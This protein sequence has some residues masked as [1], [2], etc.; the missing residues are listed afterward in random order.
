MVEGNGA[1]RGVMAVAGQFDLKAR[2]FA[3]RPRKHAC[4]PV[5]FHSRAAFQGL[6]L[7]NYFAM[8]DRFHVF[9]DGE[10]TAAFPLPVILSMLQNGAITADTPLCREGSDA[11]D[12]AKRMV[13]PKQKPPPIPGRA[14]SDANDRY[15]ALI[16][17]EA[18]EPHSLPLLKIMLQRGEIARDTP[19]CREGGVYWE[20]A[21]EILYPRNGTPLPVASRIP[22]PPINYVQQSSAPKRKSHFLGCA[23][24][25]FFVF[26]GLIWWVGISSK[27]RA[28][29]SS[30]SDDAKSTT[31]D[32]SAS[33]TQPKRPRVPPHQFNQDQRW[34]MENVFIDDP[35]PINGFI[36]RF[37]LY[38]QLEVTGGNPR[39]LKAYYF[40]KPDFTIIVNVY[41]QRVAIWRIG[42]DRDFISQVEQR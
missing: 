30:K 31:Y 15:C 34:L 14:A 3:R 16:N 18:T 24:T 26:I 6:L 35:W 37:G 40:S 32:Y 17:G 22:A 19:L 13:P 27:E 10:V 28:R 4:S 25:A 41:K 29:T 39:I 12:K 8:P 20:P 38:E 1:F 5:T 7:S 11:W 36:E 2:A 23:A 9:L 42:K 33:A 21:V